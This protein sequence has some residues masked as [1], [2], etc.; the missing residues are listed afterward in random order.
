MDGDQLSKM[1]TEQQM[2]D[3]DADEH[4]REMNEKRAAEEREAQERKR[5][6]TTASKRIV[7]TTSRRAVPLLRHSASY[8]L[9]SEEEDGLVL[10]L[11]Q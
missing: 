1:K 3:K 10:H 9:D 4:R 8:L 7:P 11:S 6:E 2:A 5:P